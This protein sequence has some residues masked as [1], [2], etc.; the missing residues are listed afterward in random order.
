M[1][2]VTD[3]WKNQGAEAGQ[4]SCFAGFEQDVRRIKVLSDF[5]DKLPVYEQLMLFGFVIDLL[6]EESENE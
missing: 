5:Y 1:T 2:K 3:R 6:V 4:Y